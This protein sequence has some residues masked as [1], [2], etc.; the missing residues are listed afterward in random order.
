MTGL[1][2][3]RPLYCQFSI[4]DQSMDALLAGSMIVESSLAEQLK[5]REHWD[6]Y[7]KSYE[8]FSKLKPGKK[9]EALRQI[10]L[11]HAVEMAKLIS[12]M[13]PLFNALRQKLHEWR[14]QRE[15]AEAMNR[16][17][18]SQWAETG[19]LFAREM[20]KFNRRRAAG[21]TA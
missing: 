5:L 2:P 10:T 14:E 1:M 6:T 11:Q 20:K 21:K 3:S 13:F 8:A 9:Q 15:I 16:L 17:T 7:V 18:T 19:A 4:D 12:S